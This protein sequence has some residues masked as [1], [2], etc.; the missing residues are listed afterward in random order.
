ML[1]MSQQQ[2]QNDGQAAMTRLGRLKIKAQVMQGDA[3]AIGP[4]KADLLDQI[5]KVGSIAA[6]GRTLGFSYRRTRDMVDTLNAC[7]QA[8]LV[9]TSRGGAGHGGA[10]LTPEGRSVLAAYRSLA[11]DL[12]AVCE[13]H[14]PSLLTLLKEP[15]DA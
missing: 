3:I 12:D 7:W 10:I 5:E 15:A 6:A 9:G 1:S 8:P 14:A 13:R 4:G 11:A 2:D